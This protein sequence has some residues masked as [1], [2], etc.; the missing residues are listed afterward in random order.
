MNLCT[1]ILDKRP[2]DGAHKPM[3]SP[4]LFKPDPGGVGLS[5]QLCVIDIEEEAE[6]A[7]AS[8]AEGV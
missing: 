2:G 5:A 7:M 3:S 8:P 1:F 4:V 6:L